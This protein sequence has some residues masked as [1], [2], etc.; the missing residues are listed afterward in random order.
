VVISLRVSVDGSN[1]IWRGGW[2]SNSY[3]D[4]VAFEVA[5]GTV[6]W[7]EGE[8]KLFTAEGVYY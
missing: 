6:G 3:S 7:I 2:V 5:N 8:G 4:T 1:A